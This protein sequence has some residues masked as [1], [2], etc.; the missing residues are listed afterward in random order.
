MSE[1]SRTY[2]LI[3]NSMYGIGASCITI[4]LNFFVRILLVKQLGEEINGLHNLFQ[5]IINVITLME[6]GISSAMIIHLYEPMK[7]KDY[8]MIQGIM[9]FYKK[10]YSY[11]ALIFATVC[12]FLS[13]F[14]LDNIVT[15]TIDMRL[16][17]T[18]FILFMASFVMNYLTYYKR[19]LLFAEQRNRISIGVTAVCEVVF[20]SLQILLLTIFHQY[21]IF[22]LLTIFEKMVSNIICSIYVDKH[23]P[24]LKNGKIELA[25]ENKTAIFNT[26][27]P[28]MLN[29]MANIVQQS[30]K[31]ILISLLLG[32]ISIVGYY[33]NYQLVI[34]MVE[35]I[36]SQFGGAFTSGFGNLAVDG[37]K[38]CMARAYRNSAF[39]LNWIACILCAGFLVCMQDFIT[40]VFGGSFVLETTS[41]I[42]L[43]LSMM[44]YLLNIPIISIQNAMG[45]HRLD[46]VYMVIQAIL[47]IVLGYSGGKIFGMPGIF[48]GLLIPVIIFTFIGK[49]VV[50]TKYAFD[51]NAPQ[52][53]T[54]AGIELFKIIIVS[55]ITMITCSYISIKILILSIF[56]KGIIAV[57]LGISIPL[58]ISW[59]T[60]EFKYTMSL[61]TKYA[62]K[63]MKRK[64]VSEDLL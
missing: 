27:K 17:R 51:Y 14:L 53:L 4:F 63:F 44:I 25:K 20:R 34:S 24:Y 3:I 23:H 22:L 33:G 19:S 16:V 8:K 32:N 61:I 35:M 39:V 52:Y 7:T 30:A 43:T 46:V 38:K 55:I 48:I 12:V 6:L 54:F 29:Q 31:S 2:N 5:S 11:I 41:V 45:L 42:A 62:L 60:S 64:N 36:Y 40:V 1:K 56:V 15:T 59:N 18:Y 57:I 49:G 13:I 9:G 26:V 37:D 10:V 50:I 28:L 21:F 58:A 47:A